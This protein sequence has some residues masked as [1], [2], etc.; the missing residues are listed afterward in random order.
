MA[1]AA[2]PTVARI[3]H[4]LHRGGHLPSST[5]AWRRQLGMDAVGFLMMAHMVAPEE[6]VEQAQADGGLRRRLRLRRRL[7]RRACC[8]ATCGARVAALREALRTS[9]VGFHAPQQPG[10]GRRQHARGDRGRRDPDRRLACAAWARA[11]ATRPLEVLA[12]VLDTLG[13]QTTGVDLYKHDGRRRG[14][15]AADHAARRRSSTARRSSSATAGVYSSFLLH[16]ERAA[17]AVRR[18]AARHPAASWA[19]ARIVGGQEDM[20]V[21]VA[22]ELARK[23]GKGPRRPGA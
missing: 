18:D 17:R 10:A 8:P 20:I 11:P 14:R 22:V 19:A 5:S 6:L 9:E 1:A 15:R 12:A 4:A 3:A 2:A 7:G 16:A 23:Q 21:D 13:L